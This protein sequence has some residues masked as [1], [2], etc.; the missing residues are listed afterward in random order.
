MAGMPSAQKE[1]TIGISGHSSHSKSVRAVM[2]QIEREGHRS[3]FLSSKAPNM[4]AAIQQTMASI[5]ALILM[6]NNL[7]IDPKEYMHRYPADDPKASRHPMTRSELDMPATAA[8]ARYE[9]ALLE[10]ALAGGMPIL[11]ICGGMQRINVY[12]GG[13]LH[14]HLPDLVGCNKHMQYKQGI[15]PHV[16]VVPIIIKDGTMLSLIAQDIRMPF[17]KDHP[18]EGPKVIMENSIHHQA[19]DRVGDGL[20]VSAVTDTVKMKDGRFGYLPEAI[21]ADPEGRYRQQFLLGVQWHPEFG[22]SAIGERIIRHMAQAAI[23][24]KGKRVIKSNMLKYLPEDHMY[25]I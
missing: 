6:G 17:C 24:A 23:A 19:I 11:G 18:A 8:R 22:A 20:L 10:K 15:A 1:I 4:K 5:D 9:K 12:C 3:I 7:D 14:Q 21:E 13:T 25:Y 16:P 2:R